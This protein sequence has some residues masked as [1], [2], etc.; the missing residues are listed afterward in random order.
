MYDDTETEGVLLVDAENAFNSLNR[1]AALNNIRYVCPEF[2]TYLIN[3]YRNP[4]KL[5]ISGGENLTSN[6]GTTQVVEEPRKF[7]MHFDLP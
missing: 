1:Q 3:T 2:S 6:E 4:S 5:Y 7:C